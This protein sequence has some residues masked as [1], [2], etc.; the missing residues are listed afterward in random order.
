MAD[1]TPEWVTTHQPDPAATGREATAVGARQVRVRCG[2]A[3]KSWVRGEAVSLEL[4]PAG[5]PS[6]GAA[7]LVDLVVTWLVLLLVLVRLLVTTA[8]LD[9][10]AVA[11][12]SVA[13]FLLVPVGGPIAVETLSHGRSLGKRVCGLRVVR[14]DGFRSGSGTPWCG[15]WPWSR[16]CRR[17]VW[18]RAWPRWCR[19]AA[20]GRGTCS[21]GRWWCGSGFRWRVSPSW[22]RP[23]RGS[24]SG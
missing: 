18:W 9:E 24:P 13:V 15:P 17:W 3:G 1:W 22:R 7:V 6:R 21:R 16:S 11:A 23:G 10:A 8:S 2:A 12:V 5:L 20:D 14:E 19:S 4:R